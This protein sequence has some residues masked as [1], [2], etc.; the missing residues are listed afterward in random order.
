MEG[1]KE[2]V[3]GR[4]R[5]STDVDWRIESH[6]EISFMFRNEERRGVLRDPDELHFVICQIIR[7]HLKRI[8][9][10]SFKK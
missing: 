5:E 3:K 6:W 7:S 8:K 1:N 2:R 10:T 4:W 9:D